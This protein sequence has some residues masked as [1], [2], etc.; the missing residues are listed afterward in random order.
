MDI[1]KEEVES[2]DGGVRVCVET[3][4]GG[5][6]RAFMAGEIY[7][8]TEQCE[9]GK[10]SGGDDMQIVISKIKEI[11]V[12]DGRILTVTFVIT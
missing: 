2:D 5:T 8:N 1:P 6:G 3:G 9:D 4:S 7:Y 11:V 12:D 10:G